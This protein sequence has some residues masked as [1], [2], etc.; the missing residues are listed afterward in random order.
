MSFKSFNLSDQMIT[1]LTHQGYLSPS[2]IQTRVIPKALKGGNIVAQSETGSGKTHAFLIPI[3]EN[4]SLNEDKLQAIIIAPTRELAKQTYSFIEAFQKDYANL[5]V[6]L[7]TAGKET[8]RTFRE[9]M[10]T[11]HIII[12]T[13]TR[14][15]TMLEEKALIDLNF[16]KTIV[17][18]EADMLME[19]G[20]FSD[21]DVLYRK[22]KLTPQIMVFSATIEFNLRKRLEKYVGADFVVE[23]DDV[24]TA[25]SVTHYAI[26]VK[27]GDHLQAIKV[28][29][30]TYNPYLLII[31]ASR[32]EQVSIISSFLV[33]N[34]YDNIMLHG[35]MSARERKTAYKMIEAN[36]K[37]I[38]V[39]SDLAA[40]GLD[41]KDVSEVLNYDLPKD[42]TYYF[43]RAGR[44][45]RFG[46]KG[47]CYSFYNVD[48]SSRIEKL[49]EQ[50]ASFSYLELKNDTIISTDKLARRKQNKKRIDVEL[51]RQIKHATSK[52]KSDVV[53]PGYKKKVRDAVAKVKRKHHR[54]IIRKDIRRQ[55]V[56]RYRKE[57][58]KND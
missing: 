48:S 2:S 36:K 6:R 19:M 56:E 9:G 25:K 53:K 32:K 21:I 17:L 51:E 33:G 23:M 15:R 40:R 38:I 52:A 46:A 29:I 31:F 27:H 24:K 3:I 35:D 22:L 42:L 58:N 41:I 47:K 20:Y 18:D 7:F 5:H 14:I 57:G 8:D 34:G 30:K 39:A 13:P 37:R 12:G 26:D 50:G 44:T 43:H 28:F 54:E 49:I 10:R 45:G 55:R 1:S 16:V 4:L 11:P